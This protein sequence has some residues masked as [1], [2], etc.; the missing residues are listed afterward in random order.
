MKK[1]QLLKKRKG[2]VRLRQG[3]KDIDTP[4]FLF[5]T[6][7]RG[8]G[9]NCEAWALWD[10]LIIAPGASGGRD[11]SAFLLED[12]EEFAGLLTIGALHFV[13][14]LSLTL[15][16]KEHLLRYHDTRRIKSGPRSNQT[17][18]WLLKCALVCKEKRLSSFRL[19]CP[20]HFAMVGKG[21]DLRPILHWGIKIIHTQL[22]NPFEYRDYEYSRWDT[23]RTPTIMIQRT[24]KRL[25]RQVL[26]SSG[27]VVLMHISA[28]EGETDKYYGFCKDKDY[29]HYLLLH[30]HLSMWY[31]LKCIK[32]HSHWVTKTGIFILFSFSPHF[33]NFLQWALFSIL[34]PWY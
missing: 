34:V 21:P 7:L 5:L 31:A 32:Q 29:S 11:S 4:F 30:T 15:S 22:E 24:E 2:T 17:E 12:T 16:Q 26:N 20:A 6:A 3:S 8:T 14:S 10:F 25:H 33:L 27:K 19:G 9:N 23:G 13:H 18:S 1:Y 28:G